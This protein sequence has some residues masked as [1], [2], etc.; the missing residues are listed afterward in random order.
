MNKFALGILYLLRHLRSSL[1]VP[2]SEWHYTVTTPQKSVP[3]QMRKKWTVTWAKTGL[4][5]GCQLCC[6]KNICHC[7]PR[8][9]IFPLFRVPTNIFSTPVPL[10][11]PPPIL[12]WWEVHC[13]RQSCIF[14]FFVSDMEELIVLL[15]FFLI[16]ITVGSLF[17]N[18]F[19]LWKRKYVHTESKML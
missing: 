15:M 12:H 13:V 17:I 4:G 16:H 8:L 9:P 7:N 18:L 2:T 6:G 1:F 10:K 19:L 11:I 14:S 5:L 3:A